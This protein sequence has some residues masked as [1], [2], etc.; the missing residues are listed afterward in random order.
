MGSLHTSQQMIQSRNKAMCGN[1]LKLHFFCTAQH[2]DYTRMGYVGGCKMY[3][4]S[5]ELSLYWAFYTTFLHQKSGIPHFYHLLA[6]NILKLVQ[7]NSQ[8]IRIVKIL[9]LQR[10]NTNNGALRR[11]NFLR[12]QATN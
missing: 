8:K 6:C 7:H 5:L 9:T 4:K 3:D 12:L 1:S 11:C 2:T 10:E